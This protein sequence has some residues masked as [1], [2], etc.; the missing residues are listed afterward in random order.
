[1]VKKELPKRPERIPAGNKHDDA[2][3]SLLNECWKWT[4]EDRPTAQEA[5]K[6]VSS[7]DKISF[8]DVH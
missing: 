6:A 7:L 8:N 5:C 2:L 4:P 3:W 1:M